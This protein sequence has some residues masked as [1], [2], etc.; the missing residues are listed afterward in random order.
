VKPATR[1]IHYL[2]TGLATATLLVAVATRKWWLV[3]IAMIAG[4]GGYI[5]P[6]LFPSYSPVVVRLFTPVMGVVIGGVIPAAP[7]S[8][9]FPKFVTARQVRAAQVKFAPLWQEKQ[10]VARFP[11]D[12]RWQ[13]GGPHLRAMTIR[14]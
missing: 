14:G 7:V 11:A 4:Y 6:Q 9:S 10:H 5:H 13:L 12:S 3:P 1:G 2:G 8:D